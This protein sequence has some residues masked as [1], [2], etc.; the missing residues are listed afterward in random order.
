MK[1]IL[2]SSLYSL[3]I[4]GLC[5]YLFKVFGI[6][7][8]EVYIIIIVLFGLK[9]GWDKEEK[10]ELENK[11]YYLNQELSLRQPRR[12]SDVVGINNKYTK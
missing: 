7:E 1:K 12:F 10:K 11:I 9:I 2:R 8:A 5:M 3:V 6:V 4:L